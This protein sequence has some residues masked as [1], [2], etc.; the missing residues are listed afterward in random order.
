MMI[1]SLVTAILTIFFYQF[2]GNKLSTAKDSLTKLD[3]R[4]IISEMHIY[5][6][7]MKFCPVVTK[8]WLLTDFMIHL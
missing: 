1:G 5:T 2:K 3:V 6:S 8:L 4:H 7:F